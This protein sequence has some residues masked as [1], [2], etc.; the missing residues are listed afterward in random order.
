MHWEMKL[1]DPFFFLSLF[2]IVFFFFFNDTATTEIYTLSLHDALRDLAGAFLGQVRGAHHDAEPLVRRGAPPDGCAALG[3]GERRVDVADA[4]DRDG[5]DHRSVVGRGD[6][7]GLAGAD[8]RLPLTADQHAVGVHACPFLGISRLLGARSCRRWAGWR[9][10][11]RGWVCGDLGNRQE[12]WY[13]SRYAPKSTSRNRVVN[14]LKPSKT[15]QGAAM[16]RH[17]YRIR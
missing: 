3:G 1:F 2:S 17:T 8:G 11:R 14:A 9:R 6:V 4:A 15:L 16:G 5:P 13:S 7:L 10:R 12:L